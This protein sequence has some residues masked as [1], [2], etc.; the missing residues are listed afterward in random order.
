MM[1][2][3]RFFL[4]LLLFSEISFGS[5]RGLLESTH[6]PANLGSGGSSTN[7][8]LPNE[9]SIS[10]AALM[11]GLAIQGGG[12]GYA[13]VALVDAFWAQA[14]IPSP[15]GTVSI[16]GGFLGDKTKEIPSNQFQEY[17][18][19]SVGYA[20]Q[21]TSRFSFGIY[22]KPA[23]ATVENTVSFFSLA[24]EPAFLYNTKS[25]FSTKIGLGLYD[26][27]FY[28]LS[29]NLGVNIFNPNGV[30]PRVSLHLGTQFFFYKNYGFRVGVNGEI[31]GIGT[32][33]SL[34]ARFGLTL[35]YK[36]LNFGIGYA[37]SEEA[38]L[39]NG[40]TLGVGVNLNVKQLSFS[41]NYA[42]AQTGINIDSDLHTVFLRFDIDYADK[43]P[44]RVHIKQDLNYF[45][46]N[47]DGEKDYINFKIFVEDASLVKDWNFSI[48]NSRR[49]VV[50]KFASDTRD[51]EKEF[52]FKDFFIYF[53]K[54][55][56]YL[57]VPSQIRW[58]GTVDPIALEKADSI[59]HKNL[60]DGIYS[61][62]FVATDEWG[63]VSRPST[64]VFEIDTTSPDIKIS[65]LSSFFSPNG[66]GIL[67]TITIL[68]EFNATKNDRWKASFVNSTGEV[69]KTYKWNGKAIPQKIIW[70]GKDDKGKP[71]S[72]G[73]YTY[74]I[75]ANDLSGNQSQTE[76]QAI[77]LIR[78]IDV[79]DVKLSNTGLSPN[80]DKKFD[81][82]MMTPVVSNQK[83]IINWKLTIGKD[84]YDEPI[85][86]TKNALVKW[87]GGKIPPSIKWNG[88][89]KDGK[90][91]KDGIYYAQFSVKYASG[92]H[93]YSLFKKII[94][95]TQKPKVN[96]KA[97]LSIFSPDGD[98]KDE[99]EVF[100][101]S[102]QDYSPITSYQLYI[103]EVS[104]NDKGKTHTV[105]FK[106]FKGGAKYPKEIYW[107][108]KSDKGSL[109][110]S[111]TEYRY[112]LTATD[113]YGNRAKS[114]EGQFDTDILVLVSERGL[115]IRI[116]N[117]EFD[118]GK[119]K[120]KHKTRA[121]IKKIHRLLER[122][123]HYNIKV[124][125]HTDD[126]GGE[127]FNLLLSEK[128]AKAVV[129]YLI[130]LGT[131]PER[132]DYQGIGEVSPL[133]PNKNWYKRSRNRRVEFLLKKSNP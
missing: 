111:A 84:V 116:S 12:F 69:V 93:P 133:V 38:D 78:S 101:L 96:V 49:R 57:S 65:A 39:L 122:Y 90:S 9:S 18:F 30:G 35:Q 63:N 37:L 36:F 6:I 85:K 126:L 45:S 108:G 17:Y 5:I 40:L 83:N 3:F 43:T 46:P 14:F 121:L 132:L 53:F 75:T 20:R 77:S 55:Q 10:N 42:F 72:E 107:S 103:K 51:F 88:T 61:Y 94:L 4:L 26:L 99:E 128:R 56:E 50:R 112:Y 92:N 105:L 76:T 106:K 129:D 34:P 2:K 48:L 22:L 11:G 98:G 73:L 114:K 124:E 13:K 102:I 119:A 21:F 71:V 24:I 64:G 62:K 117:I 81:T 109:V 60:S 125:G 15:V 91:L 79:V 16:N 97:S 131:E 82:L 59:A 1:I 86:N 110:E 123:S 28:F 113:S 47:W 120:L 27:S 74:K 52:G 68:Q 67:E 70:D 32:Y 118:L 80:H 58:D 31:I 66:D 7:M 87:G 100:S 89:K 23:L 54:K 19:L 8:L 29:H 130:Q 33:A 95:D 25:E 115:K 41:L 44:P 127:S 104:S